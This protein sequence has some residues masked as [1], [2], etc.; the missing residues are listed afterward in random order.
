[1]NLEVTTGGDQRT[2]L[3]DGLR[4]LTA[5]LEQHPQVPLRPH[6]EFAYYVI[7]D[8]DATGIA[9]VA[10]VAQALGVAMTETSGAAVT[11]QT[12]HFVARRAFGPMV[13]KAVYVSR[14]EMAEYQALMSYDGAIRAAATENQ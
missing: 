6:A 8:D 3:I 4:E 2:A 1:M 7:C 9:Q 10:A 11:A 5:F 12:T 13:Y 14:R